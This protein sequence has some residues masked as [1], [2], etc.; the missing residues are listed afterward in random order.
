M[1]LDEFQK[2]LREACDLHIANVTASGVVLAATC[3]ALAE[4]KGELDDGACKA[5]A[6]AEIERMEKALT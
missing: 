6:T 2:R 5:I 3:N 1:T 4:E